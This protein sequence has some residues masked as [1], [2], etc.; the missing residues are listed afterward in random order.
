MKR[1]LEKYLQSAVAKWDSGASRFASPKNPVKSLSS[2]EEP[3]MAT[4]AEHSADAANTD[5]IAC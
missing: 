3:E 2:G 1:T 5:M 4:E